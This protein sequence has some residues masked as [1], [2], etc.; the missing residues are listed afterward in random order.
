M[1]PLGYLNQQWW[2]QGK[3]M[4]RARLFFH[5]RRQD[6]ELDGVT[7][8]GTYIFMFLVLV[9]HDTYLKEGSVGVSERVPGFSHLIVGQLGWL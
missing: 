6:S 3:V 9:P 5:C 7:Q 2:M 8:Y 1:F 4:D